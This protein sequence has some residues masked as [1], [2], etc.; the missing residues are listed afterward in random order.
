MNKIMK[1]INL[2]IVSCFLLLSTAA[3][4]H[5]GIQSSSPKNGA[6]MK[7]APEMIELSFKGTVRLIQLELKAADG[8]LV[9][10]ELPISDEPTKHFSIP[11]PDLK[12]STYKVNWVS[13]GA[14]GHK[15]KGK[16][17]F[18]YVGANAAADSVTDDGAEVNDNRISCWVVA[19]VLNKLLIYIALAMTVGGLAAM[20]TLSRYKDRQIP[21]IRYLPVGCLLG[22]IAVTIS[23]FLQVGSFAEE[24]IS[25][26]F[27]A[28]YAD[29]LWGS[30]VGQSY[31][32]QVIGWG[33]V[34]LMMLLMWLKPTATDLFATLSLIGVFMIAAAFTLTGHNAEAPIWIRIALALHVVAAMWWIGSL[35]PLRSACD[36]LGVSNLQSLMVEFGKQAMFLVGL[37]VVAGVVISY[38]LEGNFSNLVNT[39]HGNLLLLKIGTVAVILSLA[40]LHK[41]A[42][43][44]AL[45]NGKST[46]ILKRSITIEMWV[47]FLILVITAVMSSVTGPAYG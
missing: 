40:A 24:G 41:F 30:G 2:L 47:G 4:A 13:A 20:F 12:T 42:Y 7:Q 11:L 28:D 37:L 17:G 26:M 25:G 8:E 32:L 29:I 33:L 19:I 31:K 15:I 1:I 36:V 34:V 9:N 6:V 46:A 27:N 43:V 16:F 21:F 22:F 45:S 14:D 3:S 35:Y 5:T 44:P 10:L 38:H 23:F 39:G 18:K